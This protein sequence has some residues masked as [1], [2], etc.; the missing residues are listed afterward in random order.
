MT[1]FHAR[2][3]AAAETLARKHGTPESRWRLWSE[4][5]APTPLETMVAERRRATGEVVIPLVAAHLPDPVHPQTDPALVGAY[6]ERLGAVG[7]TPGAW[8]AFVGHATKALRGKTPDRV[9]F[10]D[11]HLA[12]IPVAVLLA[13]V[14]PLWLW[15]LQLVFVLGAY[16][17]A[18]EGFTSRLRAQA[19]KRELT[20]NAKLVSFLAAS[21]A[22]L[23]PGTSVS[24]EMV[25]D[26][27]WGPE[28]GA[29]AWLPCLVPCADFLQRFAYADSTGTRLKGGPRR[30]HKA[31]ALLFVVQSELLPPAQ[32]P[33]LW[34]MSAFPG[35]GGLLSMGAASAAPRPNVPVALAVSAS[36]SGEGAYAASRETPQ[37]PSGDVFAT[38]A[39]SG[40]SA[41]EAAGLVAAGVLSAEALL[42]ASDEV[43]AKAG[44]DS[45]LSRARLRGWAT[46]AQR[47]TAPSVPTAAVASAADAAPE[48]L[49][50]HATFASSLD[51]SPDSTIVAGASPVEVRVFDSRGMGQV[52]ALSPRGSHARRNSRPQTGIVISH[53]VVAAAFSPDGA[54]IA[55]GV[56]DGTVAVMSAST[57]H[58]LRTLRVPGGDW[59]AAVAFSPDGTALA[60]GSNGRV[61]V[62]G[63]PGWG[64]AA[65]MTGHRGL[66]YSVTFVP[67]NPS[68]L[69]TGGIDATVRVWDVPSATRVAKLLGHES[70]V[71]AVACHPL[72]DVVASA[73]DDA[74]VRVW[75]LRTAQLVRT[76][77]AHA[78]GVRAVAFSPA[79]GGG[80]AGVR[81]ASGGNDGILRVWSAATWEV[82]HAVETAP[83]TGRIQCLAWSRDGARIASSVEKGSVAG[84]RTNALE[85]WVVGR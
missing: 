39:E 35:A 34:V 74:T 71:R 68:A 84:E 52:S 47:A 11:M 6:D 2:A 43:L 56:Q 37:A 75:D 60:A 17:A 14:A 65:D 57:G 64:L 48:L 78:G 58:V 55:C 54:A 79:D 7:I 22:N 53:S 82:L 33:L 70:A 44:V 40:A 36:S 20:A 45:A 72:G 18:G 16:P 23:A 46:R 13:L 61:A 81:M 15:P 27:V 29:G 32:D 80:A 4:L 41:E 24:L 76:L 59:A 66:V 9:V 26:A 12:F 8:T 77:R 73:S 38:L 30:A 63:V 10:E 62:W 31:R 69:V 28:R 49:I 25:P 85:L 19:L 42:A 51:F 83:R 3:R 5:M 50:S 67:S 21:G 1:E